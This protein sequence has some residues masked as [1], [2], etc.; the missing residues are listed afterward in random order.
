MSI[1]YDHVHVWIACDHPG[2]R[3]S[4]TAFLKKVVLP[5]E[6]YIGSD[7]DTLVRDGL[8]EQYGWKVEMKG[9]DDE[10][11]ICPGCLEDDYDE[12]VNRECYGG[13]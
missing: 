9:K 11:C 10:Y 6:V 8:W 2:C 1:K 4:D 7:M 5:D 12:R 3:E 13:M